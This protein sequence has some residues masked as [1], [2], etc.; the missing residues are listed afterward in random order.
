MTYLRVWVGR[1]AATTGPGSAINVGAPSVARISLAAPRMRRGRDAASAPS[2]VAMPGSQVAWVRPTPIGTA[3][4]RQLS[5][6]TRNASMRS[7]KSVSR[8]ARPRGFLGRR[9]APSA[10]GFSRGV[11]AWASSAGRRAN[12]AARRAGARRG[13]IEHAW[14][15][16]PS[17]PTRAMPA[18]PQAGVTAPARLCPSS[19]PARPVANRP[20]CAIT[21]TRTRSTTTWPTSSRSVARAI[22]I[23][24]IPR[25]GTRRAEAGT[26]TEV[27][28]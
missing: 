15:W 6:G 16:S 2:H 27:P 1:R 10:E 18:D 9:S 22:C 4:A 11:Q 8:R 14:G 24:T 13:L 26:T 7:G 25:G 20:P 5:P 19:D 17:R 3:A 28:A 12:S 21:P 23:T